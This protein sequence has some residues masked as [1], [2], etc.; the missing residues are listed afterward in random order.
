[1]SRPQHALVG[2]LNAIVAR[3]EGTTEDLGDG[4]VDSLFKSL[5]DQAVVLRDQGSQLDTAAGDRSP[6]DSEEYHNSKV[7]KLGREYRGTIAASELRCN[8]LA[9]KA[10]SEIREAIDAK[11]NFV[12][13]PKWEVSLVNKFASSDTKARGEMLKALH[14]AGDGPTFAA[15]M[16]AP[17]VLTGITADQRSN[18]TAAFENKHAA[19]EV[20]KLEQLS[21]LRE[22]L[23]AT[24]SAADQLAFHHIDKA[25]GL[26]S[27][28]FEQVA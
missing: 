24:R 12:P 23:A 15:I 2:A 1:M 3:M 5:R 18:Y 17:A 28:D 13:D 4:Q 10:H 22:A 11:C 27:A 20:A 21:D 19:G 7:A 8:T 6:R 25:M 9:N 14:E 16:R 26:N